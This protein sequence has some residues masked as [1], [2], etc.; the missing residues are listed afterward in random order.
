M[1]MVT[2]PELKLHLFYCDPDQ[3]VTGD[4][5]IIPIDRRAASHGIYYKYRLN[6]II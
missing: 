3:F 5:I 6:L 2:E 1:L 4:L